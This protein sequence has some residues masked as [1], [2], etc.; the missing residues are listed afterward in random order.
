MP[1]KATRVAAS[2]TRRGPRL[3]A[4]AGGGAYECERGS[5]EPSGGTLAGVNP[6][7]EP[8]DSRA[9]GSNSDIENYLA[10]AV[11]VREGGLLF[12]RFSRCPRHLR[13]R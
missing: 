9:K 2:A 4:R 3:G 6:A 11:F 13:E 1:M 7:P 8:R 10:N 12:E 5:N